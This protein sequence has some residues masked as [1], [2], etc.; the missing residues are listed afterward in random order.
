[1][2]RPWIDLEMIGIPLGAVLTH[3]DRPSETCV[4]VQLSPPRVVFR[5]EVLSLTDAA[6]KAYD[7]K[8]EAKTVAV[9]L[10]NGESLQDRRNRFESY[11]RPR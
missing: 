5:W 4:V 7:G 8:Y 6:T 2:S 9:W 10:Y 11:H 1:M 3:A